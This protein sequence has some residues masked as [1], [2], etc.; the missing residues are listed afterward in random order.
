MST[1]TGCI[2]V[3]NI[4]EVRQN[5]SQ[6][7]V[8]KFFDCLMI[9]SGANKMQH[10]QQQKLMCTSAEVV[11]SAFYNDKKQ[12]SAACLVRPPYFFH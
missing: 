5:I 1:Y 7:I 11:K 4:A 10:P 8:W 3:N 9:H 12:S 6:L 2:T